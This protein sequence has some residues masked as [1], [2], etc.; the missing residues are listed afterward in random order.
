MV[1]LQ[2]KE[3]FVDLNPSKIICLGNNFAKHAEELNGEILKE[4][5][6]FLKLPSCLIGPDEEIIIPEKSKEIHHEVELAVIISKKGKDIN[7]ND[8]K[9][10]IFGYTIFL[11]ITA[12]DLQWEARNK[13][14]PWT[15]SKSFDT[16]G[17]IG[18]KI[19]NVE[20]IDITNLE[21]GLKVNGRIRQL[22]RLSN[23]IFGVNKAISFISNIMTLEPYDIV[24]MGTP[25]GVGLLNH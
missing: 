22:S 21:I 3:T 12:R 20:D 14:L 7:V 2:F 4:P 25:E 5:I 18:P 13:G 6:I 8:V 10:Y 17:P 15:I 9:K 24:A 19:V 11:D 23:M 1:K 16:F